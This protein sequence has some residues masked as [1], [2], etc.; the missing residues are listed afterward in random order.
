MNIVITG[1]NRGVGLA[2]TRAW[3]GLGATVYATARNVAEAQELFGLAQKHPKTLRVLA[4]DVTSDVSV[5][6]FASALG[7]TVVDVLVNNAGIIGERTNLTE[8]RASDILHVFDTNAVG[9]LRVTQALL[10]RVS[11]KTG[12]LINITSQMGSIADN[13]SGGSYAYRMSKAAL[14]MAN[15]SLSVDLANAGI[16]SVVVHPGWVAT[17][18]GGHNAPTPP[19]QSAANIIAL[20][21]RLTM[22]DTGKFFH[23][24]GRELPW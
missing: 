10:A 12:K 7:N 4:L 11:K 15:K 2:L 6:A 3:L 13:T 21:E 5:K 16:L 22:N 9:T 23:A 14:N 24:D 18:M 19:S 1:A 20:T 8:S 17:D